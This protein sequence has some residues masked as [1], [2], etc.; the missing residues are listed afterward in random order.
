M[1]VKSSKFQYAIPYST[2]VTWG[3]FIGRTSGIV[4][5]FTNGDSMGPQIH[6]YKAALKHTYYL[7]GSHVGLNGEITL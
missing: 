6:N 5:D 4:Q 1:I 3:F 2:N 7:V